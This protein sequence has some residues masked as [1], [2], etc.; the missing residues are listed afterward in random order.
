MATGRNKKKSPVRR[1]STVRH[2]AE[3]NADHY[4]FWILNRFPYRRNVATLGQFDKSPRQQT[5]IALDFIGNP[6]A[7]NSVAPQFPDHH[8]TGYT[9]EPPVPSVPEPHRRVILNN[10]F[11]AAQEWHLGDPAL[12]LLPAGKSI[13]DEKLPDPQPGTHFLCYQ[14]LSG[15]IVNREVTLDD[16][17]DRYLGSP[18]IE[19]PL[20]PAYFGVPV[21]K[22]GEPIEDLVVHYA[23]YRFQPRTGM[24][25]P[26]FIHT[27]DQF[28]P[29]MPI[30]LTVLGPTMLAV[31]SLKVTWNE[32]P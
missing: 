26:I 7:K 11:G 25:A 22:N 8:L 16:Q 13:L 17:F 20:F 4:K 21:E 29:V 24:P 31:P 27:L 18:E 19:G 12:L 32:E 30:F 23:I 28:I 5:T 14:V 6:V 2:A 1:K 3:Q 10:Q 15:D 9:L